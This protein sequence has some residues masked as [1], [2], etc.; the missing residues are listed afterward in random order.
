M[1]VIYVIQGPNLNMLG[2]REPSRYG[3]VTLE[4]LHTDLVKFGG[5]LGLQVE[6]FQ[7]NHEGELV[8]QIH[9]A[10]GRADYIIINA[11]AYTHTSV[12]IRDALLAVGIK[13]IEVHISNIYGREEFRHKSLIADVVQGQITGLGSFGYYLALRAAAF[14]TGQGGEFV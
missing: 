12:A 9:K 7:S 1:P 10:K 8:E 11:A 6:C 4:Q 5:E 13:T 2:E 14:Y 3:V